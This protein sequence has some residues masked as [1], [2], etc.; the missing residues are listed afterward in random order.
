MLTGVLD[1][2]DKASSMGRGGR[3]LLK[4]A[5]IRK[6]AIS[7]SL[8]LFF[9]CLCCQMFLDDSL[10][11]CNQEIARRLFLDNLEM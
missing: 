8:L 9:E 5:S 6:N 7:E 2:P 4:G 1:L 11:S 10:S 3:Y